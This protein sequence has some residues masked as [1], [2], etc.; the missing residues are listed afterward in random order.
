MAKFTK[1]QMQIQQITSFHWQF[2][3]QLSEESGR[4]AD[5]REKFIYLKCEPFLSF[6][7]LNIKDDASSLC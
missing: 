5:G 4:I 1:F 3:K 2:A 6:T 7:S